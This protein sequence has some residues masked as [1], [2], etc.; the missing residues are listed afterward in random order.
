[1]DLTKGVGADCGCRLHRLPGHDPQGHEGNSMVLG[2][3]LPQETGAPNEAR[4][5]AK[6]TFD[7]GECWLNGQHMRTG[8]A[9]VKYYNREL[10]SLIH[11]GRANPSWIVSHEL[12]LSEAP[13]AYKYFDARDDGWTKVVL[14]PQLAST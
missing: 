8:Q 5:E 13:S 10:R 12:S 9:N 7:M 4:K 3:P 1:M 2:L 6:V 11:E 14:K